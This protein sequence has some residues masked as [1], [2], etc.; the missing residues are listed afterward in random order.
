MT[1]NCDNERAPGEAA[2]RLNQLCLC[3]TL[4]GGRSAGR[5]STSLKT[6]R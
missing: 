2:R 6:M 3:R 1:R 4:D 5:L